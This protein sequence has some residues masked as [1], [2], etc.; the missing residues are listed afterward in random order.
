MSQIGL[1]LQTLLVNLIDLELRGLI[2]ITGV[3]LGA[4]ASG[5]KRLADLDLKH[6]ETVDDSGFR[7]LAYYSRNLRQV[8][9]I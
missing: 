3:G 4:V 5:C 2:R 8:Q 6:C 9:F 7:S 1:I